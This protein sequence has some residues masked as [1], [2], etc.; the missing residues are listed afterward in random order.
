MEVPANIS[1]YDMLGGQAL[2]FLYLSEEAA[3]ARAS[4]AAALPDLAGRVDPSDCVLLLRLRQVLLRWAKVREGGVRL[5]RGRLPRTR[6]PMLS[7]ISP[8]VNCMRDL[9]YMAVVSG[10]DLQDSKQGCSKCLD[11]SLGGFDMMVGR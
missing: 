3:P 10:G 2:G 4:T 5:G 1:L 11:P 8:W 7:G 6:A 9:W